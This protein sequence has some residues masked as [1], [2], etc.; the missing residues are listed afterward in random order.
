MYPAA[1]G[2]D[3]TALPCR[4]TRNFPYKKTGI[5]SLTKRVLFPVEGLSLSRISREQRRKRQE[6]SPTKNGGQSWTPVPT[7]VIDCH[8][9]ADNPVGA[10][11]IS[12]RNIID[13]TDITGA[14]GMLPYGL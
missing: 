12:A 13:F 10:D 6:C 11:S 14:Y 9:V 4:A 2:R 1:A 3:G 8:E 7:K 5:V